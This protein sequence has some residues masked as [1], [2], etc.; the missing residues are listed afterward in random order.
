MDTQAKHSVPGSGPTLPW[1]SKNLEQQALV[2]TDPI[3]RF[4]GPPKPTEEPSKPPRSQDGNR[5]DHLK[6]IPFASG[7]VGELPPLHDD[8]FGQI[9]PD[10]DAKNDKQRQEE[11]RKD[12]LP[13]WKAYL[14]YVADRIGEMNEERLNEGILASTK[15]HPRHTAFTEL[16]RLQ[17]PISNIR[18]TD[19]R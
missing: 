7:K 8:E 13:R 5:L 4:F 16:H 1:R 14:A 17:I 2:K 19:A 3:S 10:E 11:L 6:E 15:S 12:G 9:L 18:G